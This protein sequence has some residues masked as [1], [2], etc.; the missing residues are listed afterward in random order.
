M[1]VVA[2]FAGHR[3]ATGLDFRLLGLSRHEHLLELA[4]RFGADDGV[5]VVGDGDNLD[6][7]IVDEGDG[8]FYCI[9]PPEFDPPLCTP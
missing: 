6:S 4:K 1:T 3:N 8:T 2:A 7:G 5:L 9:C